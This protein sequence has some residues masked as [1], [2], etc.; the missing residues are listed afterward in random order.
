MN[1]LSKVVGNNMKLYADDWK[2]LAIVDTI[3]ETSESLQKDLDS[4]SVWMRD[5]K[6][7]LNIA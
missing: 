5:W 1:D 3:V 6:M 2:I 4:I 7:K